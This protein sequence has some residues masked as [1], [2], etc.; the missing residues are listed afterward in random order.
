MNRIT[1]KTFLTIRLQ[2]SKSFQC[3]H[4]RLQSLNHVIGFRRPFNQASEITRSMHFPEISAA[5][6]FG[7]VGYGAWYSYHVQSQ[8]VSS[9]NLINTRANTPYG[10]ELPPGFGRRAVVVG[11]DT[12]YTSVIDGSEPISKYTDESG[13]KVLEMLTPDQ[14]TQKLGRNQE[15][16]FVG[17]GKGV[18]RYDIVQIPSNDP[19]EDDHSEKIFE[20]PHP[21]TDT[22][23]MAEPPSDW[24]F[25]GVYDGHS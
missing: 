1:S 23:V 14:A 7:A 19:I 16:F 20:M 18:I 15:S 24:M 11:P 12:L 4:G 8:D 25:W 5:I 2:S 3:A 6:L 22:S 17:R 10:P 9:G 13:R 21:V